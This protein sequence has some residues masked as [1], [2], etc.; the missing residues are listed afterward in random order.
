MWRNQLTIWFQF[1]K[2]RLTGGDGVGAQA[3]SYELEHGRHR[4]ARHVRLLDHLLDARRSALTRRL[5][6]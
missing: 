5:R 2:V 4:L 3:L 1:T 6:R